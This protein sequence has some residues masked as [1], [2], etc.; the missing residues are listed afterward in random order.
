VAR[1]SAIP[2][3]LEKDLKKAYAEGRI[4]E[5]SVNLAALDAHSPIRGVG[6]I[7]DTP[8]PDGCSEDV[9]QS[10]VR[11]LFMSAGWL[12]YHTRRSK[13]SDE[14]FPDCICG[15]AG[16]QLVVAE[17]KV[18]KAKPTKGQEKWLAFF[19]TITGAR[20]FVW[21]PEDWPII[22]EAAR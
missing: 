19:R 20:V 4:E 16:G 8:P 18:R 13:G 14:G 21:R 11:R 7:I 1:L 3:W 22:V 2:D 12:F 6:H 10:H 17:L 9:F 5:Q 15:R